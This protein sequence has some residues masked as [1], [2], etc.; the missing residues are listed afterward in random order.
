MNTAGESLLHAPAG[1]S[2]RT[3]V[4][5]FVEMI[6]AMMVGMAFLGMVAAGLFALFDCSNLLHHVGV[7]A[8]L[9]A[10]DM[11]IGMSVWMRHRGHD[12]TATSE[13]A[14]AMFVPLA[15]LIV[16]FG[17]GLLSGPALL[18]LMHVL[19]LPAMLVVM[20]RRRDE[21]ARDH[22]APSLRIAPE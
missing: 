19:M 5:H 11:T 14:G 12:W 18:G 17:A 2:T 13:M 16:P 7:R 4:R 3:F 9:M 21:Y 8:P 6:L 10:L 15:I 20:L 22:R 1:A